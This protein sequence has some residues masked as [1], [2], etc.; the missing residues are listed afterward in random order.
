MA[1]IYKYKVDTKK[2]V[3]APVI[4]VLD[5]QIV[6]G[7]FVCWMMVNPASHRKKEVYFKA[8]ATGQSIDFED[9]KDYAY[10]RTLVDDTGKAWH[11]HYKVW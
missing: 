11:I 6:D 3:E 5:V 10:L 7:E 8:F 4:S 2:P 9:L 1:V